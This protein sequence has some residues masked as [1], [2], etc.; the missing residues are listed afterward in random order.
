MKLFLIFLL[1]ITCLCGDAQTHQIDS[2]NREVEKARDQSKIALFNA[3]SYQYSFIAPDKSIDFATKALELSKTLNDKQGQ[4]KSYYNLGQTYMELGENKTALFNLAKGQDLSKK[5]NDDTL[6]SMGLLHLGKYYGISGAPQKSIEYVNASLN[7]AKENDLQKI[8]FQGYNHLG[9]I[10]QNL[11]NYNKSLEYYFHSLAIRE[12]LQDQRAISICLTNIGMAFQL[13]GKYDDAQNYFS[14]ALAIDRLNNDEQ[15]IMINLLNIGVVNQK[16]NAFTEALVYFNDAL[17]ISRKLKFKTDEAVLLGNIGNSLRHQGKLEE[18][19]PYLL[20]ALRMK[21]DFSMGQSLAHTLND[22]SETYLLLNNIDSSK[23]YAEKAIPLSVKLG[24]LN[25]LRYGYQHL[26]DSYHKLGDYK[27]AYAFYVKSV[28]IKDSLFSI[29]KSKQVEELQIT[30]ETE[31]KEQEITSLSQQNKAAA[32]RRDTYAVLAGLILVVGFLLYYNQRLKTKK[33]Q[34]LLEKEQAVEK[35][36]SRFF[37]NI[38]HEFRTPLTLILAPIATMSEKILDPRLSQQLNI[39]KKNARRLLTLVNQLLDLSKLESGNLKLNVAQ[40]NIISIIKG[41]TMSFQS[42]AESKQT[43]LLVQSETGEQMLY[44]DQ[45]KIEKVL[46]NL[47]S[48]A[49]KFTPPGGQIQVRVQAPATAKNKDAEKYLQ[50]VVKDTGKGIP[51]NKVTH[52]FDRFYQA[53]DSLVREHEGS[54]IGLALAK[55]FIDLHHGSIEVFSR[56]TKGTEMVIRLPLGKEHFIAAGIEVQDKIENSFPQEEEENALPIT[57]SNGDLKEAI[58][59]DSQK[60][61]VLLIEDNADVREYIKEILT[62]DYTIIQAADGEAGVEIAGEQIPDLILSDVMMPKMD[63]YEVCKMLKNAEKTS[64][65]PI[66]LLTAKASVE[67]KLEGLKTAADDYL[68]KP[69][70]PGELLARVNNLIES[71]KKLRE[72]FRGQII[73]KPSEIAGSSIDETFLNR[74]MKIVEEH[75]GDELFGVERLSDKMGMSR[76]QLHRKLHALTG[77][78][79]NQLIRSFRLNRAHDL[80][81]VN[82]TTPA[83]IAYTVGFSSPSYFSKCFR[84]QFG[85]TPSDI[86]G[87]SLS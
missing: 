62:E 45:D 43:E 22:L 78:G 30:Y 86:R 47:L 37:T 34:Q 16:K 35:M 49:F 61:V 18:A 87:D 83:E 8:L 15:G 52:I 57:G 76:S 54:G 82:A 7:L 39:M 59:P 3:L 67:S 11:G 25:Q 41:V 21:S 65:I 10:Y 60:P 48:N 66:I 24:E 31:K 26:S 12:A 71:R 5:I 23:A 51:E 19:I 27:N 38:T 32:F 70:V 53:D 33:N 63:G 58:S 14:K 79:P 72:K 1:T 2:L 40:G 44:F 74:L 68:T 80:L 73:L 17:E 29:E 69:F 20:T 81:K 64:H 6:T 13:S 75:M 4:I 84:E 55:E 77:K 56:E 46:S 36:Q 28:N 85:Y 9:I 42:L 50:I